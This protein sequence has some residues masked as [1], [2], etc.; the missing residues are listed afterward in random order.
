MIYS[1]KKIV[2]NISSLL[3]TDYF[4]F[5]FSVKGRPERFFGRSKHNRTNFLNE[6]Q[7]DAFGNH[8]KRKPYSTRTERTG[9]HDRR[10]IVWLQ[11]H[12][13]K[14]NESSVFSPSTLFSCSSVHTLSEMNDS[15]ENQYDQSF[16]NQPTPAK[17]KMDMI[18]PINLH[19]QPEIPQGQ[20]IVV[21]NNI[22]NIAQDIS[23]QNTT[24]ADF[25]VDE[26]EFAQQFQ[27]HC[28]AK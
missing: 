20:A 10:A 3:L 24:D 28:H 9:I 23:E 21:F 1:A 4:K 12:K 5:L 27:N 6:L 2:Q 14:A 13:R 25:V 15:K 22:T 18:L 11:N 26:M 7:L 8:F 19:E 16:P 17:D